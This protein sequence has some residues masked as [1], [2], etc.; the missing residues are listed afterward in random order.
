VTRRGFLGTVAAALSVAGCSGTRDAGAEAT[1]DEAGTDGSRT[2]T[3]RSVTGT[4]GS[5]TATGGGLDRREANVV[6]VDF[7]ATDGAYD[8]AVTL[9]HDDEGEEGYANWWQVERLDGTLLARRDLAHPH[10][11]QPFTRSRTV[12]VPEGVTCLVVRGHDQTHGYGGRA[13]LVDPETGAT[14]A[15]DQGSEK[16]AVTAADCP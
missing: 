4:D 14:A 10:A 2:A 13:M 1:T 3:G 5:R 12:D 15:I 11:R 6:G 8:V 9:D 16:R 7:R